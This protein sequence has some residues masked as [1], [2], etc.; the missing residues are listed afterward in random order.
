MNLLRPIQAR[1]NK[2]PEKLPK[3]HLYGIVLLSTIT[4]TTAIMLP[5]AQNILEQPVNIRMPKGLN[6][7]PV[8]NKTQVDNTEFYTLEHDD[9]G[10]VDAVDALDDIAATEPEWQKYTVQGG[11]TLSTI[12]SGLGLPLATMYKL[13]DAD[14]EKIL[15]GLKPGQNLSLLIDPDNLLL[16]FKVKQDLLHTR[17]FTREGSGYNSQIITTPSNWETRALAG[18]VKGSFY[19]SA[20]DAGLSANQIQRVANLFQ[21]KLNFARDLRQGDSFKV[22]VQHEFVKGQRTGKSELQAVEL[23][24]KGKTLYAFR[25]EDGKFYDNEGYSLERGFMR[26]PLERSP[27]ISSNFNLNRKHPITG[28]VRPHKG[29]D[30]AVPTGTPVVAPSDGV[31]VKAVHHAYAGNYLVIRHGR[32]YTTRFLHL[33]KFLVKQGDRV[34]R[35]QRIALSGNTGRSTGPH[36]HYE[37]HVNNRAVDAMQVKL[38]LAEGLSGEEKRTFLATIAKYQQKL[39]VA[40]NTEDLAP[41]A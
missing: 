2:R 11:D 8:V 7:P 21:W 27:R 39:A 20:R 15:D 10:P 22:L 23:T 18:V 25:H 36:L 32:Q 16:E 4:L 35:G 34:S 19:L 17:I 38:P 26:I 24:N 41:S 14:Q 37:F 40:Y 9:L 3:R 28:R 12:F 13:L 33:S 6:L 5:S 1:F 30:F 31:V 29:T